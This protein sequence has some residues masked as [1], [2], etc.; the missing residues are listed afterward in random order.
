MKRVLWLVLVGG[1]VASQPDGFRDRL[2]RG[3]HSLAECEALSNAARDRMN[4]CET[5]RRTAS[6]H[7]A[8]NDLRETLGYV[9]T[10]Q[11]RLAARERAEQE[12]QRQAEWAAQAQALAN[13]RKEQQERTEKHRA[14]LAAQQAEEQRKREDADAEARERELNEYRQLGKKGRALQLK[15]CH[16]EQRDP[17]AALFALLLRAAEDDKEKAELEK[18]QAKRVEQYERATAPSH[19]VRPLKCCDGSLSTKC[20]CTGPSNDKKSTGSMQGCCSH[21]GG[22]CGC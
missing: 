2:A 12:R 5:S 6:C 20:I 16:A 15:T 10:V 7:D 19:R 21:H 13:S 8:E 11:P 1:C 18:A 4:A 9:L 14:D 3:C 22:V 17:C